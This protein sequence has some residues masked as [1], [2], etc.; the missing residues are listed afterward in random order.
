[1]LKSPIAHGQTA[2]PSAVSHSPP[3]N[4]WLQS[5]VALGAGLIG[6][7]LLVALVVKEYAT[8]SAISII[9]SDVSQSA[10]PLAKLRQQQCLALLE[11]L[12]PGD[13]LIAIEF[14]NLPEIVRETSIENSL[15]LS[16]LCS[17]SP[18]KVQS[19]RSQI[20]KSPGTSLKSLLGLTLDVI[21]N[22]RASGN[23]A[24]V[25]LTIVLHE[26]EPT[27]G[28]PPSNIGEI[29]QQIDRITSEGSVVAI[30]GP[31]GELH[32]VLFQALKDNPNVKICSVAK[33]A[34]QEAD[35]NNCANW[36]F[37]TGRNL[38]VKSA[39]DRAK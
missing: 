16:N 23:F 11:Q 29:K 31:T 8:P 4:T 30:M 35:V 19:S 36:A 1:M 15:A 9:A 18:E 6:V 17:V 37:Q 27:L 38:H 14:A 32:T 20:G 25:V 13:E 2:R 26:I 22:Q 7:A 39:P 33:E 12:K 21:A 10:H 28:Q 5:L 24:P 3:R 34:N